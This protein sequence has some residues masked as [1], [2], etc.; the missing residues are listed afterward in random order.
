MDIESPPNSPRPTNGQSQ[1]SSTVAESKVTSPTVKPKEVATSHA[2]SLVPRAILAAPR[3]VVRPAVPQTTAKLPTVTSAP[4]AALGTVAPSPTPSTVLPTVEQSPS[5][6][7]APGVF[8]ECYRLRCDERCTQ[9]IRPR[10]VYLPLSNPRPR[11]RMRS[12]TLTQCSRHHR[13]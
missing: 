7:W 2:K 5:S 3:T 9:P 12:L 10:S 1:T 13:R 11:Q 8:D 4:A 6:A